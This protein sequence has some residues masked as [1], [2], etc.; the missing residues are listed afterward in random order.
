[1]AYAT[2]TDVEREVGFGFQANADSTPSQSQVR[3]FLERVSREID[4]ILRQNYFVV[5]ITTGSDALSA[6]E[7]ISALGAAIEVLEVMTPNEQTRVAVER[8]LESLKEK[9]KKYWDQLETN[10]SVLLNHTTRT[11]KRGEIPRRKSYKLS[12]IIPRT[13]IWHSR[14][15]RNDDDA[16]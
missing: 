1:M 10:P 13:H 11:E 4:R 9:F 3:E 16:N 7:D 5:P 15:I 2:V 6:L 8:R 14:A 12:D